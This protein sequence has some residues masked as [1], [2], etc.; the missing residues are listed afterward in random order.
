VPKGYKSE[1]TASLISILIPVYNEEKNVRMAYNA[2]VDQFK[3]LGDRYQFEIIFTDNH[4]IDGTEFELERLAAEDERVK[5]LRFSR[6]FGFQRSVMTAYHHAKGAAA[7]QL[8]CDLQDPP[9]M[10][11]KFL[12]TWE[13][14]HDVVVGIRAKRQEAAALTLGRRFFYWLVTTISDDN[15]IQN[16]GDFRLVD[17]SVIERLKSVNDADPYMRGL[18]SSLAARQTGITYDRQA[19]LHEKSKFPLLRLVGFA[20]DGIF[21]HSLLPLRLAG[22][23]GFL[24]FTVA[25]L[26]VGYYLLAW[27]FLD[28]SWPAGF[29][30]T[31]LL[32]LISL[33][34]NGMFV[35][36]LGEYIGR[37]YNQTRTRPLTIIARSLNFDGAEKIRDK[38]TKR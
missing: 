30:T 4:S 36:I 1:K 23:T 28:Q 12:E 24:V 18:I 31:T 5:V 2:V 13:K 22:Y 25:C 21:N 6:N 10:F 3:Q 33:G 29:A 38:V 17:R 32:I 35:G 7:I 14:G 26:L 9:E 15:I 27:L 11:S 20:A 16:A 37:I 34:L 8:D 19:R